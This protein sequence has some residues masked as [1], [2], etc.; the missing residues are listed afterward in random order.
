MTLL[1]KY[2]LREK[3]WRTC[4]HAPEDAE[5]PAPQTTAKLS[6]FYVTHRSRGELKA[7]LK[8]AQPELLRPVSRGRAS[9]ASRFH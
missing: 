3:L 1:E 7:S 4:Q 5:R 9:G 8:Q 2:K 6:S